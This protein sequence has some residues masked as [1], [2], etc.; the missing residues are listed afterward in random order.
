MRTTDGQELSIAITAGSVE[1][2]AMSEPRTAPG[3]YGTEAH[4]H[5]GLPQPAP[6]APA[7]A[8]QATA[9]PDLS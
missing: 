8:Q 9:L 1:A 6:V 5:L 3:G 2:V 4:G 7:A